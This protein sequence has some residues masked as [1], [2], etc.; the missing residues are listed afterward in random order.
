WKL[1]GYPDRIPRMQNEARYGRCQKSS[2]SSHIQAE[3]GLDMSSEQDDQECRDEICNSEKD[4]F[5]EMVG[6]HLV[7]YGCSN[8]MFWKQR[9]PGRREVLEFGGCRLLV[10]FDQEISP[11]DSSLAKRNGPRQILTCHKVSKGSVLAEEMA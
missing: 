7:K 5:C 8:P 1:E 10:D 6:V 9:D 4:C 11:G 2:S 3:S